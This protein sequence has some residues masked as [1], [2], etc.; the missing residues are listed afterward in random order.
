ML[1]WFL[2]LACAA[3]SAEQCTHEFQTELL[4][5]V[6]HEWDWV[7]CD[8][9]RYAEPSGFFN[10]DP[11]NLFS[12]LDS[13]G[14]TTFYDS[15]CGLPLFRAPIGRSF[16]E[17]QEESVEGGWPSFRPDEV[18]WENVIE[19]EGGETASVCGTHL[20][21]NLPDADGDRY[22][23]DLACI[24]GNPAEDHTADDGECVR[25]ELTVKAGQ[26]D[27]ATCALEYERTDFTHC[28]H[29]VWHSTSGDRFIFAQG[30]W[31]TI[32][33]AQ[34]HDMIVGE[35]GQCGQNIGGFH[36]TNFMEDILGLDWPRYATSCLEWATPEETDMTAA[37]GVEN[38]RL[39]LKKA[40]ELSFKLKKNEDQCGCQERCEAM[41]HDHWTFKE[42]KRKCYCWKM[43]RKSRV[44][45]SARKRG[46]ISS[47]E[48]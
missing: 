42:K 2:S 43:G 35:G 24:A 47:Q 13:N 45:K 39:K 33:G 36:H 19:K 7:C 10:R 9:T 16:E 3:V 30:D 27:Y 11:V 31:W 25:M 29:P 4:W 48:L 46:W 37:C 6:G 28:G 8:N 44:A 38:W 17:W 5:D 18:V 22:C 41:G 34:W 23:I 12:R 1:L 21:H 26:Q 40:D 20:G 14:V 15:T 32:T